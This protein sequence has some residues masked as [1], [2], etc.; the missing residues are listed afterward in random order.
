M[1]AYANRYATIAMPKPPARQLANRSS[2]VL[3]PPAAKGKAAQ[4]PRESISPARRL[5]ATQAAKSAAEPH[6]H[7]SHVATVAFKAITNAKTVLKEDEQDVAFQEHKH[8][9]FVPSKKLYW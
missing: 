7:E 1:L 3:A 5:P 8:Y 4:Q 6:S 2:P 9:I